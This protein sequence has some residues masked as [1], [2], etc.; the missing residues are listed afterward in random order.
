MQLF[1][2][3]IIGNVVV[4]QPSMVDALHRALNLHK[5]FDVPVLGVVENMSS[6]VCPDCSKV[7]YPFGE[8]ST[9]KIVKDHNVK[10]IGEIPISP[11][12]A[13]KQLEG[14]AIL[15]KEYLYA[16]DDT[17]KVIIEAKP[18]K[19]GIFKK[20]SA[21]FEGGIKSVMDK[22]IGTLVNTINVDFDI[23][24]IRRSGGF[25]EQKVFT[26]MITDE[27]GAKELGSIDLR[28]T[29]RGMEAIKNPKHVDF[30]IRTDYRTLS[31]MILR[32]R[33]YNGTYVSFNGMDAWLNGDIQVFGMGHS[34]K[35]VAL[36]ENIFMNDE[37]MDKV[38]EKYTKLLEKF[39]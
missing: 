9:R 31:R 5:Y 6:Y 20:I 38:A 29:N 18:V 32:K 24:D 3:K 28:A 11:D 13:V 34:A 23:A 4:T 27:S 36:W 37:L 19:T 35:A 33:K 22:V 7:S 10:V 26:L 30:E 2:D 17:C 25:T 39:I 14:E 8:G 12:I 16:I 1:G 15:A 21:V